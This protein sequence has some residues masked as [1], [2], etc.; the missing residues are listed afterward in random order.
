MKK[1]MSDAE[2]IQHLMIQNFEDDCTFSMCRKGFSTIGIFTNTPTLENSLYDSQFEDFGKVELKLFDEKTFYEFFNE[3][4]EKIIL[5][6]IQKLSPIVSIEDES[7][8]EVFHISAGTP[9]YL[10]EWALDNRLTLETWE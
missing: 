3:N 10:Q 2:I 7:C 6:G 9:R 4:K 5:Q 1:F 8:S